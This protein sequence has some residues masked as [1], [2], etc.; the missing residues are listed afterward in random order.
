MSKKDQG[1]IS[2]Y[3][4]N[5]WISNG[6]N[7]PS[8]LYV[9][10]ESLSLNKE[11]KSLDNLVSGGRAPLIESQISGAVKP[12]GNVTFQP[13]VDDVGKVFY[14][15][16]Q[17]G[18]IKDGTSI[19]VPSK[20]NPKYTSDLPS[21]GTY[22]AAAGG[23]YSVSFL[24]KYFN[25]SDNGGTNST[26]YKHG[27]CDDLEMNMSINKDFVVNASYKF[28]DYEYGTAIAANPGT[29]SDVGSYSPYAPWEWFQGTIAF[30][31]TSIGLETLSVKCSNN[32]VEKS[33][34]GRLNP[35]Q[36]TFRDHTVEGQFSM[37][38]PTDGLLSVGSMLDLNKFSLS[39]TLVNGTNKLLIDMPHCIRMPFDVNIKKTVNINTPF[40]AMQYDGTSPITVTLLGDISPTA[41][42]VL[43]AWN[44]ARSIG[45]FTIYDAG[46]VART[47]S[48]YTMFDRDL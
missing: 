32:L 6:V 38:F 28:R 35:E 40:K 25:T 34:L 5:S 10:S 18:T 24:K 23:V 36:F 12:A 39:G 1:F 45:E 15:H 42:T 17:C 37:D 41:P 3:E 22:G 43:D 20:N 11:I 27:I 9:D 30:E 29:L 16:F 31:N 4:D 48:E 13:R 2:I 47:L 7:S 33:R 26:Y 21:T 19:F 44:G 14:S 46:S 8:A